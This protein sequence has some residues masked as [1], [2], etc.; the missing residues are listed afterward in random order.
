MLHSV[1]HVALSVGATSEST[2]I[3]CDSIWVT[4]I[5]YVSISSNQKLDDSNAWLASIRVI[6]NRNLEYLY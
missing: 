2:I 3:L 1:V 4:Y 6:L 5:L